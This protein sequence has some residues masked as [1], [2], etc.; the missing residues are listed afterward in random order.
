MSLPKDGRSICNHYD[1]NK[2]KSIGDWKETKVLWCKWIYEG[3]F[4]PHER[5]WYHGIHDRL[6]ERHWEISRWGGWFLFFGLTLPCLIPQISSQIFIGSLQFFISFQWR[7]H[8]NL[9]AFLIRSLCNHR[10]LESLHR[11]HDLLQGEAFASIWGNRSFPRVSHLGW[12]FSFLRM[13]QYFKSCPTVG[14]KMFLPVDSI[15][16]RVYK[17]HTPDCLCLRS[18]L[19]SIKHL[20]KTK[21][22]LEVVCTPT[23]K[24]V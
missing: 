13:G 4:G 18:C 3:G 11:F 19:L 14:A 9:D 1:W 10:F 7:S 2:I 17:D 16:S 21:G 15:V 6:L 12:S 24:S 23:P 22:T 20:T 8:I 5:G